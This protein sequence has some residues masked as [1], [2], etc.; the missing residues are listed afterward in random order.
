MA[1][2]VVK[3][4]LS[5][6]TPSATPLTDTYSPVLGITEVGDFGDEPDIIK[7]QTID[8]ER[9]IKLKGV[10]DGG[11][12]E[13]TCSREMADP[14]QIALRAA[15]LTDS[16]YNIKIEANDKPTGTNAKPT[17]Q[18]VRGLI[19]T[20]YKFGSAGDAMSQTFV[21]EITAAPVTVAASAT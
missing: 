20:K 11:T 12:F 4:K 7:I 14:G 15:A 9:P 6:G 19:S 17:T 1:T 8:S 10:T 2:K 5:I 3:S 16:E 13:F 21:V 18:Y